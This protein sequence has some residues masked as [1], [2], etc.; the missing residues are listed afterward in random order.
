MLY[1]RIKTEYNHLCNRIC[2]IQN[3]L[4]A[5]PSGKLICCTHKNFSKWYQKND[6]GR[7]YIPKSNRLLAEQLAKKK[8]LSLLLQDLENEKKLFPFIYITT[9][10]LENRNNFLQLLP[11]ISN[12]LHPILLLYLR[13][14]TLG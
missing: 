3:E 14:W 6:H 2:C 13:N 11:N 5:L 8:Y 12:Y 9:L 10:P 4:K 1:E 7:T